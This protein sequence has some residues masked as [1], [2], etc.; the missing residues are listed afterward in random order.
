ME[1]KL[2]WV[3]VKSCTSLDPATEEQCFWF[4]DECKNNHPYLV[5]DDEIISEIEKYDAKELSV[6]KILDIIQNATRYLPM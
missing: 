5:S 1:R 2:N 6:N 3:H 4:E